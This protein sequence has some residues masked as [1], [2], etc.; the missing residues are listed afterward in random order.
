M[1]QSV[2]ERVYDA[3]FANTFRNLPTDKQQ[4]F[5]ETLS[6]QIKLATE[7]AVCQEIE[8]TPADALLN[9]VRQRLH[10]RFVHYAEIENFERVG[11]FIKALKVISELMA[12]PAT[13]DVSIPF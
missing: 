7:E 10:D 6:L 4:V 13:L 8:N 1:S 3:T 9:Y 5:E 11:D 2:A 12:L